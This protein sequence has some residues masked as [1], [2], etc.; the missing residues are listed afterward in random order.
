MSTY[1]QIN[2]AFVTVI[3]DWEG[4]VFYQDLID[5]VQQKFPEASRKNLQQALYMMVRYGY[6]NKLRID[7][8]KHYQIGQHCP[9][10]YL[11]P[12][13][14]S[15][16]AEGTESPIFGLMECVKGLFDVLKYPATSKQAFDVFCRIYPSMKG[17]KLCFDNALSQLSL[18]RQIGKTKDNL[19]DANASI[20]S[21]YHYAS[22]ALF[23]KIK[24]TNVSGTTFA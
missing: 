20:N 18:S 24:A 9:A 6:L 10:V 13:E 15:D 1:G 11:N 17:H 8:L 23:A 5:N 21:K 14:D 7:G 16:Y 2:R 3:L 4:P 22:N 12:H 19:M